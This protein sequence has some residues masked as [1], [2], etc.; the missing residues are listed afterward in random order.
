VGQGCAPAPLRAPRDGRPEPTL[1]RRRQAVADNAELLIASALKDESALKS[2]TRPNAVAITRMPVRSERLNSI[3][4]RNFFEVNYGGEE[5]E[6]GPEREQ[7][8]NK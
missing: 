2:G 4:S 8:P 1:S 3:V 5:R 6:S 7:Q